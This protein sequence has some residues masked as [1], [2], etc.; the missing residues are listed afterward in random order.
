M[1]MMTYIYFEVKLQ[2]LLTYNVY[3]PNILQDMR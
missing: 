3:I 1:M 2:V